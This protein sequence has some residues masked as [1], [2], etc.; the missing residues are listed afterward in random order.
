MFRGLISTH[1]IK[2]RKIQMKSYA[3]AL[4]ILGIL[5]NTA[6]SQTSFK[7]LNRFQSSIGIS[8]SQINS[9]DIF[10]S[11]NENYRFNT[12]SFQLNFDYGYAQDVKISVIPGISFT[13]LSRDDLDI[14]PSP[15]ALLQIMRIG[16]LS[17]TKLRY[18]LLG[19]V[20]SS[21]AQ[22]ILKFHR[23]VHAVTVRLIGGGG[24]YHHFQTDSELSFVPFFGVYYGNLWQNLSTTQSRLDD[25]S[26]AAWIGN[27]GVELIFSPNLS[28]IGKWYF[29]FENSKTLFHIGVN[30]H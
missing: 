24:I 7:R 19:E 10:Q 20:G 13:T 14:P 8:Y 12:N 16:D 9:E 15:S 3:I 23:D 26:T 30:F 2:K 5:V 18:F 28:I 11:I 1:H 22:A 17:D 6:Y 25:L 27:T 21:Y 29:S 4:M